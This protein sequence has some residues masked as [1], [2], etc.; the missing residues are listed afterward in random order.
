MGPWPF[1]LGLAGLE[2]VRDPSSLGEDPIANPISR[3]PCSHLVTQEPQTLI[4][5]GFE[6]VTTA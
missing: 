3:S 6:V 1:S 5:R 2:A 4:W